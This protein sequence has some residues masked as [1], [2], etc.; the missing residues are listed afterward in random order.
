V[1]LEL[2]VIGL[3]LSCKFGFN[4]YLRNNIIVLMTGNEKKMR[5]R[6]FKIF[7]KILHDL[8]TS[9]SNHNPQTD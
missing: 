2:W 3:Q 7:L 1:T 5:N 8:E 6:S 4:K 9:A